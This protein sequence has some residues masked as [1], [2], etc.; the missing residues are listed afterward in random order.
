MGAV[1]FDPRHPKRRHGASRPIQEKHSFVSPETI[2]TYAVLVPVAG[3]TKK[4][5]LDV[6]LRLQETDHIWLSK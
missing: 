1:P 3:S 4:W 5:F 2:F 6:D